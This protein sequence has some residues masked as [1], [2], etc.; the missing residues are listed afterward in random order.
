MNIYCTSN[1]AEAELSPVL[2][3]V[4]IRVVA[5][6]VVIDLPIIAQ[7]GEAPHRGVG[8]VDVVVVPTNHHGGVLIGN[9]E[10][11]ACNLRGQH[12]GV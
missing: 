5:V 6:Q 12:V 1:E 11:Q 7:H 9:F 2:V 3:V 4:G 10:R 8:D